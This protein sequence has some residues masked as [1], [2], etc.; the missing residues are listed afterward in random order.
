MALFI[1]MVVGRGQLEIT[2]DVAGGVLRLRV[3]SVGGHVLPQ[4]AQQFAAFVYAIVAGMQQRQGGVE[5][6][7]V[8]RW[9]VAVGFGRVRDVHAGIFGAAARFV[10]MSLQQPGLFMDRMARLMVFLGF[11][12]WREAVTP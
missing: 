7:S 8:W 11:C 5:A 9:L 1:F 4:L 6:G 2:Q 12:R 3:G 10:W